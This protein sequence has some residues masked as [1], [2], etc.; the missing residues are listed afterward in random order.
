MDDC[1]ICK[2][3]KEKGEYHYSKG[4]YTT[5]A[6]KKGHSGKY[7]C[8]AWG[9]GEASISCNFCPHCGRQLEPEIEEKSHNTAIPELMKWLKEQMDDRRLA[10]DAWR[11]TA[12]QA[13][14]MKLHSMAGETRED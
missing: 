8:F 7:R 2:E 12:Y 11:F 13:V 4:N 9:E 3:L 1:Y 10:G 5:I 14:A 6:I